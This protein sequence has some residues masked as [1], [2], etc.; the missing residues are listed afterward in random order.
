MSTVNFGISPEPY[1]RMGRTLPG[2]WTVVEW[3]DK[4][5]PK[6]EG[7]PFTVVMHDHE[8]FPESAI[9]WA[10]FYYNGKRVFDGNGGWFRANWKSL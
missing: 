7:G 8:Q 5:G 4:W 3:N 9:G 10:V 6:P 2:L 1:M